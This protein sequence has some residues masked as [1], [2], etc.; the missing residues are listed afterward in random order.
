MINHAFET[1]DVSKLDSAVADDFLD[2]TERGDVRGRDS[3]IAM[4]KMVRQTN[5]DMKMEIIRE[6]ADD[7]YVFSW[8]HFSGTSDGTMMA[9]GPYDMSSIELA[10]FRDGKAIEHWSFMEP[11]EM[12]KMMQNMQGMNPGHNM[13][14]SDSSVM[15]K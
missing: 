13:S 2:H 8:M 6:V 1:G 14:T 15:K 10:K 11:R 7:E 4:V 3:L 5:K 12:M 9:A